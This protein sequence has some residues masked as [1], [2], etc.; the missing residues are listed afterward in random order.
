MISVEYFTKPMLARRGPT[1]DCHNHIDYL[2]QVCGGRTDH[3]AASISV[4]IVFSPSSSST[5]PRRLQQ[6]VMQDHPEDIP[7]DA[8]QRIAR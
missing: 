3:V 5:D 8:V 6:H 2:T 7:D 4:N 1:G